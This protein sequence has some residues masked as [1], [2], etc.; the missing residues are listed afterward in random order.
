MNAAIRRSVPLDAISSCGPFRS[1]VH[2]ARPLGRDPEIRLSSISTV[3]SAVSFRSPH[4]LQ[5]E[6][7]QLDKNYRKF[8]TI[9]RL[10][11]SLVRL[12]TK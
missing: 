1:S 2:F 6:D 7:N 9:I 11:V 3:V 12:S 10:A 5:S 8:R 4:Y